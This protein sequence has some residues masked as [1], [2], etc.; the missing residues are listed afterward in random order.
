MRSPR[1]IRADELIKKEMAVYRAARSA[2]AFD[3]AWTALE[4]AHIVSQP[5]LGP[6]IANHWAMLKFATA[7]HDA[8]EAFGQV[9]RLALA[10]LGALTGRVPIGNTGRSSVSAF[11]SMP[12]PEDLRESMTSAER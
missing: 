8:R 12:V 6:H 11:K 1:R 4:R 3:K 2:K 9:V 10:P 7:Q 5:F